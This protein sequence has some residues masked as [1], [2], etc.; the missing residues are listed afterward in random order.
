MN[1]QLKH[2]VQSVSGVL[3]IQHWTTIKGM[4]VYFVRTPNLPMFDLQITFDAGSARDGDQ[5]GLA[6]LTNMLLS[7][8][9]MQLDADMVAQQFEEVGAEFSVASYRDM[10]TV[11]IR[12]LNQ[13]DIVTSVLN[14]L[15][16]VIS[17]PAFLEAG[18]K[19]E[20]T[21]LLMSLKYEAQRPDKLAQKLFFS[22]LYPDHPYANWESGQAQTVQKLTSADVKAFY[23][24]Y[25]VANNAMITIVGAL[26]FEQARSMAEKISDALETGERAAALPVVNDLV[27][28]TT[29]EKVRFPSEQTHIMVGSPGMK[30]D[31]PDFFTLLVG[32]HILGG[33]STVTRIFNE[34]RHKRGLAYDAHSYFMPMRER[35]PFII[36]LQTKTDQTQ[37]AFK[38]LQSTVKDFVKK[39]PTI[40][41][42]ED[43]KLNIIGGYPLLF[44]SNKAIAANL[45]ILGFYNLPLNYFDTYKKNIEKVSPSSVQEAFNR[46]I[47]PD[48]MVVVMVGR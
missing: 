13:A 7:E 45:T 27:Q 48:K 30:R 24:K 12:S 17:K 14:T 16:Q 26:T 23:K 37:E 20:Q 47:H 32:N 42:V 19:R 41:E 6:S 10:A 3:D 39:G 33:N 44:D 11:S 31:D 4:P 9:T 21:Q 43:A 22:R 25:Y 35:G 40:Q 2:P 1:T 38:I 36:G 28:A 34:I 5:N 29:P 46:R 15:V 18:F 8:G